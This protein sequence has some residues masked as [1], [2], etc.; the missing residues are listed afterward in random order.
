[1]VCDADESIHR[2]Y[3]TELIQRSDKVDGARNSRVWTKLSSDPRVTSVG[4]IIRKTGLDELPQLF[5]VVRGDLSLVGPRP[6][7]PYEAE[8]Y[9]AWQLRRLFSVKP[10]ITGLWQVE[11]ANGC[12]FEEMVRMDLRYVR[13]WSLLLD[14]K[15]VWKTIWILLHRRGVH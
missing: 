1:M 10:G 7:L 13:R 2:E 12:T 14:L 9:E 5:N 3:V 4:R 11:G 8:Q 6:A 15:L